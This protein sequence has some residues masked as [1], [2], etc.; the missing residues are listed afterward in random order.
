MARAARSMGGIRVQL[1]VLVGDLESERAQFAAKHPTWAIVSQ[2]GIARTLFPKG[3]L[4]GAHEAVERA[5]AALVVELL[6]SSVSEVCIDAANL[7]REQRQRWIELAELTGRRAIACV[8]PGLR[9]DGQRDETSAVASL[10]FDP[11]SADEGFAEVLYIS[12]EQRRSE[13]RVKT[14]AAAPA[15]PLFASLML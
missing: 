12:L 3:M 4:D 5:L 6:G 2:E 9:S 13:R 1:I 8:M 7:S 10:P 11:P 14:P 15:L